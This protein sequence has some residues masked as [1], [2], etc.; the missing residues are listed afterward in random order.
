MGHFIGDRISFRDGSVLRPNDILDQFIEFTD[1]EFK[2][3]KQEIEDI[4]DPE[5]IKRTHIEIEILIGLCFKL[6]RVFLN[7]TDAG[8]EDIKL[9]ICEP[10]EIVAILRDPES[11]AMLH[12]G[13]V[14]GQNDRQGRNDELPSVFVEIACMLI[15][16]NSLK[17][18]RLLDQGD[19]IEV[20]LK[21]FPHQRAQNIVFRGF[22]NNYAIPS[23]VDLNPI[24]EDS[25]QEVEA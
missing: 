19:N 2:L 9:Y 18:E 20:P 17:R 24:D 10:E 15:L 11:G 4:A 13:K 5:A 16:E 3:L 12:D 14:V 6:V 23:L 1:S 21:S 25:S 8:L 7:D 22:Q